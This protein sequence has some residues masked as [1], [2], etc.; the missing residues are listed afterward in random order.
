MK[1]C[2]I[3]GGAPIEDT[4]RIR[5]AVQPGDY[6]ICCDSGLKHLPLL[7]RQPDLIIG[8]FDS[9][10]RPDT[11]VETIVLPTVKDDTD[12]AYAVKEALRRGYDDFLLLGVVGKRLDHTWANVCLLLYLDGLGKRG[13][14]RDDYSEISVVSG[15]P[16][17]VTDDYPFFSLLNITGDAGDITVENA[18]Y[19]LQKAAIGCEFQY[20]VSNEVLPGKAARITVGKGRLLLIKICHE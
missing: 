2:V 5:G 10:P 8:D 19:N 11:D 20:G 18:K 12:T 4:A 16:A 14:I 9:H 3:V 13:V 7:G 15:K 1:R 17:E 6:L